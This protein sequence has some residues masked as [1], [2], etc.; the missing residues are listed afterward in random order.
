MSRVTI[1]NYKYTGVI[2]LAEYYPD[3]LC[4]EESSIL[5]EGLNKLKRNGMVVMESIM[6]NDDVLVAMVNYK[7]KY[8]YTN[9]MGE[10]WV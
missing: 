9:G 5:L 3:L 8:I 4:I 1:R 6:D 2:Q 7:T 10:W